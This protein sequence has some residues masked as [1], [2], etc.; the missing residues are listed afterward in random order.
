MTTSLGQTIF[1]PWLTPVRVVA[2]SN[3]SGTYYNGMQ[4]DGVGA[5]FEVAASSLTIDSVVME[6]SD[7]VL[8]ASQSFGKQNGIYIV[9]SI[10]SAV[11][12]QRASDQQ[13]LDQYKCGQYVSIAAGT[14]N[15][16]KTYTIVEPL[17]SRLGVDDMI[18]STASGGGGGSI[19]LPTVAN[20]IAYF[21][22]VDGTISSDAADISNAG[23]IAAGIDGLE[24]KLVSYPATAASGTFALKAVDNASGFNTIISN[25]IPNQDVTYTLP[26][27]A[28]LSALTLTSIPFPVTDGNIVVGTAFNGLLLDSG[29]SIN[30][31]N[32]SSFY[33]TVD[34]FAIASTLAAGGTQQIIGASGFTRYRIRSILVN[35]AATQFSGG[36]GN[37]NID[38][39]DGT[40]VYTTIS[41][42]LIQSTA[43][44]AWGSTDVPFPAFAANTPTTFM[45]PIPLYMVYSGGTTDYDNGQLTITVAY[46]QA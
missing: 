13:S 15:A 14:D 45:A 39:T 44:A 18:W 5:T 24:G 23:D 42:A 10:S 36:G 29:V 19:V 25:N 30:S 4:D 34:A 31:L 9:I 26:D 43:N 16:G 40:N 7:R 21:T 27:P 46:T 17:P 28:F 38:L 11:I 1:S 35:A 2:T 32:F 12:L 33:R 8:F 3:I 20:R 22:D 6:V 41:A 37:R